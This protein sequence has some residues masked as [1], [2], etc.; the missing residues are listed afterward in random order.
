MTD[1]E[2]KVDLPAQAWGTWPLDTLKKGDI[3][4]VTWS[5]NGVHGPMWHED[6]YLLAEITEKSSSSETWNALILGSSSWHSKEMT[7]R[8]QQITIDS[9]DFM[10]GLDNNWQ[11]ISLLARTKDEVTVQCS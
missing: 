6:M 9:K 11:Q 3:V 7:G 10:N 5:Y 2:D 8:Y 1:S 4:R